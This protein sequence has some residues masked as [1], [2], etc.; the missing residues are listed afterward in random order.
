MPNNTA[1][2]L[3]TA[4][5]VVAVITVVASIILGIIAGVAIGVANGAVGF[6]VGPVIHR[7]GLPWRA[8]D[9]PCN[10]CLQ[11]TPI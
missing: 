9:I 11:R 2:S 6:L 4:A 8:G 10:A 7:G 3:Q 1:R 5:I